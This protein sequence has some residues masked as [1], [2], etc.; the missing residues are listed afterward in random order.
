[1][2]KKYFDAFIK[3]HKSTE[4][5]NIDWD[6]RKNDWLHHINDSYSLVQTWFDEYKKQGKSL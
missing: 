3:Q 1:M 2:S 4:E 6:E 5:N